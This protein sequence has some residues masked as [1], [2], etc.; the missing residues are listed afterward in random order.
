MEKIDFLA[1]AKEA[2][3]IADDKKAENTV[4]LD[5]MDLTAIANYFVIATAESTPQI[6]AICGEI[7]KSFKEK[8]VTVLR[9]EG[10]NSDSWRVIDYGGLVIHVMSPNVRQTYNLENLWKDAKT[11]QTDTVEVLKVQ[12]A[13]K[14]KEY[15]E[16]LSKI[17]AEEKKKIAKSAKKIS[18]KISKTAAKKVSE[19]KGKIK[20]GIKTAKEKV[21]KAKRTVKAVGKGIEAFSKTLV[22]KSAPKKVKAKTKAKS[23]VKSKAKKTVKKKK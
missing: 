21:K 9:R 14:V 3:K 20:K 5:V 7:E 17:V 18:K 23:K 2:A 12:A 19:A 16:K 6:N 4:I 11:V 15:T 8:G 13:E 1:L 22:K 10:V